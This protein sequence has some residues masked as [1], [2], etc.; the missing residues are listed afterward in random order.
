MVLSTLSN[1][2]DA[3]IVVLDVEADAVRALLFDSQARRV[4]GY[5]AQLPRRAG[6]AADCLDEMHRLVQAA[7]FR[8]A[9]VVGRAE[10]EVSAE[11]RKYWPAFEGSAWFPSLPEGA[12]A[13]LGSGCVGPS[14]FALV[15][16]GTSLLG[17][18][19]QSPVE[20][21]TCV[22]I[23]EKRWL[24]SGDVP[25]AGEAHA[26]LKRE[27]KVKG[28]IEG[29]LE[30]AAGDDPHL[31][32]LATVEGRFREIYVALSRVVG[33]AEVVATGAALLKSPAWT[34]R[35]ANALGVPL[36]LCTEPEPAARGAALWALERV[37]A[38]PD[39]AALEASMGAVVGKADCQ[40]AAGCQPA[41]HA[42]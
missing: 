38:I 28:S 8:I 19:V 17:T 10:S 2:A 30:T 36:T 33:A 25:E 41:P 37:G 35:I 4:E 7:G 11:D 13:V 1:T 24:L 5:S 40:S 31:K 42:H 23:D 3:Y 18:V 12:G 29:Y 21:L 14:R 34:Q 15:V 26:A 16:G 9:A 6:A 22:P 27:L 20:A 39:M 32:G